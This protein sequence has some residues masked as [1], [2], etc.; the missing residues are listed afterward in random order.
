M[1]TL[2]LTMGACGKAGD[3]KSDSNDKTIGLL[4][5]DTVTARYEQFDHPL[6][7]AKIKALC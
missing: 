6:I 3:K 2:A 1:A 4:L 5:P 7:E